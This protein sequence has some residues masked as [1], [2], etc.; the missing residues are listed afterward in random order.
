MTS[1]ASGSGK[2]AWGLE[3][4]QELSDKVWPHEEGTIHAV[5]G[6]HWEFRK[7]EV[8]QIQQDSGRLLLIFLRNEGPHH[9]FK[10]YRASWLT[11]FTDSQLIG[12][13]IL[14]MTEEFKPCPHC[15][16]RE[17]RVE[18]TRD[19]VGA[20]ASFMGRVFCQNKDCEVIAGWR[21]VLPR[22][23]AKLTGESL[24]PEEQA[25]RQEAVAR[26][27]LM[28]AWNTRG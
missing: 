3:L 7:D 12:R 11:T 5:Q 8:Y 22:A 4:P 9:V 6:R 14:K 27:R 20:G 23:S 21:I 19:S 25:A 15:G 24:T 26:E 28:A 2:K 16:G 18:L 10:S 1:K 13:E 17:L